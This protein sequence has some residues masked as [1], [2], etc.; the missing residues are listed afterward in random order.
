MIAAILAGNNSR[1]YEQT[2]ADASSG[3]GGFGREI[4]LGSNEPFLVS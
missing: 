3:L 2:P 1:I 4:F